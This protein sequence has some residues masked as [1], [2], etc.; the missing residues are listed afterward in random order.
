MKDG[1]VWA[2]IIF[3]ED[4]PHHHVILLPN[5]PDGISLNFDSAWKWAQS[6]DGGDLPS[7]SEQ[8]LLF[9]NCKNH[10]ESDYYW[11]NEVYSDAYAWCQ[12]FGYGYQDYGL[13]FTK[14]RGVAVRR[15]IIQ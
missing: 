5:K 11:S 4:S 12:Y 15:L 2:G 6:I 1:E 10:F 13:K 3:K 7:R 8:S 14:L 9:A